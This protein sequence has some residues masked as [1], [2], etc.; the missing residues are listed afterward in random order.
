VTPL[1]N[2]ELV[3]VS[4]TGVGGAVLTMN[5]PVADHEVSAAVSGVL[6]PCSESTRQ[7]FCPGVS[8]S[9]VNEGSVIWFEKS[10]IVLNAESFAT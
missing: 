2:G 9:S 4:D 8:V 7:N 10:S 6:S 3:S 1:Y 5:V